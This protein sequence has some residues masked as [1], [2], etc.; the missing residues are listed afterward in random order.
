MK[1]LN[2]PAVFDLIH[3]IFPVFLR[4]AVKIEASYIKAFGGFND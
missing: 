3:H 1:I 2:F 4:P